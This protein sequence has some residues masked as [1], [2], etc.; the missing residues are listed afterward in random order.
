VSA[1]VNLRQI[2][3]FLEVARN[4]S[5]KRTA[6]ALNVSQPSVTKTV[7]ELEAALGAELFER[8]PTGVTLTPYG[9]ALL[10]HA[11]PAV[12]ELTAGFSEIEALKSSADGCIRIGGPHLAMS[13]LLPVAVARLKRQ[14]PQLNVSVIPGTY[15]QLLP[16]LRAGELDMIFGRRGDPTEMAGLLFEGFFQDRL[17]ITA[18]A[19][20]PSTLRNSVALE[21]LVDYPWVVPLPRTAMRDCLN[22]IFVKSRIP[23]PS[24]CFETTFGASTWSYMREAGAVAALP[25]N[26][27]YD[28]VADGSVKI[29]L[30]EKTWTI[31]EVGILRR[32][33]ALLSQAAR[34]LIKELR[35]AS[36]AAK[37]ESMPQWNGAARKPRAGS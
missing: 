5:I 37:L 27:V 22:R 7:K 2:R 6:E 8:I 17:V 34:L 19:D 20:H 12:A 32:S 13:R 3:C 15:E 35:Q 10:R 33:N 25:S 23:F 14:R 28:E 26:N 29:V 9:E 21:D 36:K 1:R 24:N 18:L 4:G 16:A 11:M 30:T 31:A